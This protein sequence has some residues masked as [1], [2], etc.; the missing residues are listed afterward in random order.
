NAAIRACKATM[1]TFIAATLRHYEQRITDESGAEAKKVRP[2]KKVLAESFGNPS[3]STLQKLAKSC[4]HLVDEHAPG[5][6]HSLR[7]LMAAYPTLG[8]VGDLLEDLE[9]LF[10]PQG[11]RT[12]NKSQIKKPIID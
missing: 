9:Q 1:M 4:Y 5:P 8:P 3:L 11:A 10:P 2:I 12:L 6:L 7:A